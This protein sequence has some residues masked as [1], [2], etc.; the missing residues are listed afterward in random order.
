[1]AVGGAG[2]GRVR[3]AMAAV[4]GLYGLGDEQRARHRRG[5]QAQAERS[6]SRDD[7]TEA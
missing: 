5:Q 7:N 3:S 2:N 6:E 1:M 4:A